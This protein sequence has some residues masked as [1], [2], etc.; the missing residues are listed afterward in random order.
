LLYNETATRID[1]QAIDALC[2][3]F[4]C[5]VGDLLEYKEPAQAKEAGHG[6]QAS[7]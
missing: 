6:D 1:L 3:L 2:Q 7:K 4:Q 5:S